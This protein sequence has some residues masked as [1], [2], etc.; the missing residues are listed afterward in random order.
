MGFVDIVC[1]L[2]SQL[3]HSWART[4]GKFL[5]S[6]ILGLCNKDNRVHFIA[7]VKLSIN[8]SA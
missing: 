3:Y 2:E 5:F 4:L 8:E 6:L 1:G 7:T